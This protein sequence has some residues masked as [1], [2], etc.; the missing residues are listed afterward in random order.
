[1]SQRTRLILLGACVGGSIYF[2]LRKENLSW[3]HHSISSVAVALQETVKLYCAQCLVSESGSHL[4]SAVKVTQA[5]AAIPNGYGT[6][7]HSIFPSVEPE[8]T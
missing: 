6:G 4:I 7:A 5:M 2:S 3:N 8:P 1:M